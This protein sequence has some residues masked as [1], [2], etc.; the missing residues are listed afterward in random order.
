MR[1]SRGT[2]G[3][4][5]LQFHYWRIQVHR[6][7]NFT[8]TIWQYQ[9]LQMCFG[10]VFISFSAPDATQSDF[11]RPA[12]ETVRPNTDASL[13]AALLAQTL[14]PRCRPQDG[15]AALDANKEQDPVLQ[16]DLHVS[17]SRSLSLPSWVH[18]C[19]GV[20]FFWLP[21]RGFA[22]RLSS[23]VRRLRERRSRVIQGFAPSTT[24]ADYEH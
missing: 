9:H 1:R 24:R 14:Q 23:A 6:Y 7:S 11:Q 13:H 3:R 16:A 12:T 8:F 19:R 15:L 17:R 10:I 21:L 22:I 5:Q 20:N 18:V 2:R 4:L